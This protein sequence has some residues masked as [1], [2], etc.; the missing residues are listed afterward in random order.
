[1]NLY[2]IS[3]A[4]DT[5]FLG[6]TVVEGIT[7]TQALQIAT[8]NDL[9]PGGQAAILEIPRELYEAPDIV[10]L[11]YKL[12]NKEQMIALGAKRHGSLEAH[13]RLILEGYGVVI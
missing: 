5:E 1:M 11:K 9:N 8:N 3:F 6:S 7:E 13:E 2:Y 4:T 10:P 12:L